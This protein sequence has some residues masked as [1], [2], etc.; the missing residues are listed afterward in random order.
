MRFDCFSYE[1]D[2]PVDL[3][4]H[5]CLDFFDPYQY[6]K[7]LGKY[8]KYCLECKVNNTLGDLKIFLINLS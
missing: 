6:Q 3:S 5:I 7:L 1:I 8:R 2:L 4:F